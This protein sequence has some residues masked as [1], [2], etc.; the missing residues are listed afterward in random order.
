LKRWKSKQ[1]AC[2][3]EYD[4]IKNPVVNPN[5]WDNRQDYVRRIIKDMSVKSFGVED[6]IDKSALKS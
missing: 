1:S 2:R 4:K 5:N 6:T 3:T